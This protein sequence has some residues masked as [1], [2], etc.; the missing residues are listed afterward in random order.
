MFGFGLEFGKIELKN[1][2]EEKLIYLLSNSNI[3]VRFVQIQIQ[4]KYKSN[5]KSRL[6]LQTKY[7]FF[8]RFVASLFQDDAV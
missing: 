8:S 4:I 7:K 5:P 3:F 6:Q 2:R 1:L